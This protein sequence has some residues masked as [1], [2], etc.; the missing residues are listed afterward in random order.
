MRLCERGRR[1]GEWWG[2][3]LT[4]GP[5]WQHEEEGEAL[6]GRGRVE[7]DRRKGAG[8]LDWLGPGG[9]AGE[10][11]RGGRGRPGGP[12]G[13]GGSL[14]RSPLFLFLFEFLVLGFWDI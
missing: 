4:G 11:G 10:A 14:A 3:D 9:R 8:K 12:S 5:E 7:R 1:Q 13:V 6:V 2:R